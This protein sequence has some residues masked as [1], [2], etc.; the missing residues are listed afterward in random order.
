MNCDCL[1]CWWLRAVIIEFRR[2][3]PSSPFPCNLMM[4]RN[5]VVRNKSFLSLSLRRR[6]WICQNSWNIKSDSIRNSLPPLRNSWCAHSALIKS[7][8]TFRLDGWNGGD[9]KGLFLILNAYLVPVLLTPIRLRFFRVLLQSGL[10]SNLHHS[11]R[12]KWFID[13]WNWKNRHYRSRRS[14]PNLIAVL[15]QRTVL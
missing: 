14:P 4:S 15:L 6:R 5:L 13:E 11:T 1:A 7:M 8:S 10:S 9:K 2:R 12:L 3:I